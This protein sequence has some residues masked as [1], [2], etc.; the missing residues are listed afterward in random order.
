MQPTLEVSCLQFA[1]APAGMPSLLVSPIYGRATFVRRQLSEA[2]LARDPSRSILVSPARTRDLG[3]SIRNALTTKQL[4]VETTKVPPGVIKYD[5]LPSR[6]T[7]SIVGELSLA[8]LDYVSSAI[9]RQ[10]AQ[11]CNRVAEIR[12]EFARQT[13]EPRRL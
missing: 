1:R 4:T 12:D 3:S 2:R 11:L 6:M 13:Y 8:C 9:A 10:F 7:E 5:K